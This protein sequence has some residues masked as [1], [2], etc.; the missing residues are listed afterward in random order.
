M[1][2]PIGPP[3]TPPMKLRPVHTVANILSLW[4]ES[5]A[6]ASR[7]SSDRNE[8]FRPNF[9]ATFMDEI[10]LNLYQKGLCYFLKSLFLNRRAEVRIP[11]KPTVL[12]VE[13]DPNNQCKNTK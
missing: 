10:V 3:K 12:P 1:A 8:R 13:N 6:G 11:I 4:F 2:S 5:G 9:P 7:V